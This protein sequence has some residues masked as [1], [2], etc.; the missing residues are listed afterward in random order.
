MKP[1]LA[2]VL[3]LPLF[4]GLFNALLGRTLPRRIGETVACGVIWGAFAFSLLTFFNFTAPVK[5]EY[6]SWLTDFSFKAPIALYLDQLSLSLTLMIT[7]VCGL[8]HLYSIGYMK[9]E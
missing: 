3:L 6:A 2:I 8:I 7:F 1:C 9:D 4:G 5:V